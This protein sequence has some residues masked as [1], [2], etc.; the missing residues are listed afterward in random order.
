MHCVMYRQTG[1]KMNDNDDAFLILR[2]KEGAEKLL[3]SEILFLESDGHNVNIHTSSG[4]IVQRGPMIYFSY[5]LDSRMFHC[6]QSYIINLDRIPILHRK[7][8][9][10]DNGE[11]LTFSKPIFNVVVRRYTMYHHLNAQDR[12]YD[13]TRNSEGLL[14]VAEDSGK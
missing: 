6:H 13:F 2:D 9:Y 12:R 10:F 3:L 8:I 11:T 7:T 5:F 4:I 1:G 14:K